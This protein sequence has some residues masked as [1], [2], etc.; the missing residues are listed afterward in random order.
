MKY[1]LF[2]VLALVAAS[3]GAYLPED[4]DSVYFVRNILDNLVR[5]SFEYFRKLLKENDPY[6]LPDVSELHV[7]DQGVDLTVSLKNFKATKASDFTIDQLNS[8]LPSLYVKLEGTLPA[9]HLEGDYEVLG[10]V[11][12]RKVEGKGPC[13]SE[14]TLFKLKGMLEEK[15]E[16]HEL[17]VSKL[18]FDYDLKG[19]AFDLPDLKVEGMSKEE[20]HELINNKFFEY[21]ENNKQEVSNAV[22]KRV[23]DYLNKATKGKSLKDIMDWF[24][25]MIKPAA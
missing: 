17:Q 16:K 4:D 3:S 24:K 9:L 22:A 18:E 21:L 1:T 8:D 5:Q 13:K 23:K 19:L 25:S 20:V 11:Q 12:G 14:V 10:V 15:V 6:P 2:A 7:Q